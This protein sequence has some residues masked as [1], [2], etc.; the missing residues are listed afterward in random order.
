[1]WKILRADPDATYQNGPFH[2][3]HVRPGH[4]LTG[5]K[6]T[7]FGPLAGI[8]HA[9][10]GLGT[11]VKMHEHKN[12]EILSYLWKGSMIHEDTSGDKTRLSEN[13]LM[14]M[15]AGT[16]FWHEESTPAEPAEMLQIFI[17]PR[18]ADLEGKVQFMKRQ[19][20]VPCSEWTLLA[21]QEGNLAPLT[22]RQ[23]VWFFDIRLFEGAETM[24]PEREGYSTF[25]YV[26]DGEVDVENER[27]YK[28]DGIGSKD[29]TLPSIRARRP[30]TLV[31]FLVNLDAETTLMGTISGK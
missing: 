7:A 2:I 28:G 17:R 8:D 10:L 22:I 31:C 5:N 26:V 9:N 4:V 11:L 29:Q 25:L 13:K 3:R 15:N 12:D 19:Q 16:S 14:M 27:L 23:Q 1:M 24:T 30:S 21:A 6:D 18:A 20:T